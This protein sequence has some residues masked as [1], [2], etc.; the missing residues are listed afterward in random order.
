MF[1]PGPVAG[2]NVANVEAQLAASKSLRLQ[3]DIERFAA[4][5]AGDRGAADLVLAAA[6]EDENDSDAT[7]HDR[8]A[9]DTIRQAARGMDAA[10][11]RDIAVG[12][13]YG[14]PDT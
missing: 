4:A 6:A 3:R 1:H 9:V 8:A 14:A 12:R 13:L 2:D 10:F 5:T 7:G 11:L